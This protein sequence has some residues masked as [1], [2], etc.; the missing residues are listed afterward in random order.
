DVVREGQAKL[1]EM[2]A[3]LADQ[4][5]F[6]IDRFRENSLDETRN[7]EDKNMIEVAPNEKAAAKTSVRQ[8]RK[9]IEF[10]INDEP[11]EAKNIP[12]MYKMG[13]EYLVDNRLLEQV[14]LPVATG[15]KRY[16]L[17]K[18][19]IHPTGKPFNALVEYGGFFMEAHNNRAAAIGQLKKLIESSGCSFSQVFYFEDGGTA[20]RRTI[21]K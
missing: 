8:K 17:A 19:P 12:E 18:Q 15:E 14:S 16:I 21:R 9:S 13:L 5:Q 2:D 10:H 3:S 20:F 1:R 11:F 6:F 7:D 4:L